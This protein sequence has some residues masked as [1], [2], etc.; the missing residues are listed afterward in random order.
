MCKSD[1]SSTTIGKRYSRADEIGIPFAVT[2]DFQTLD[3]QTVTLRDILSMKQLRVPVADLRQIV[4]NS[5]DEK[6]SFETLTKRYPAVTV[7]ETDN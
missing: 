1:A 7:D 4:Q 6:E 2:I 3:D 5:I